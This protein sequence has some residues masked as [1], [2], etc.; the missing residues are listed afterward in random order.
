VLY[1]SPVPGGTYKTEKLKNKN[2]T[3]KPYPYITTRCSSRIHWLLSS[4]PPPVKQLLH[5]SYVYFPLLSQFGRSAHRRT[6]LDALNLG[7]WFLHLLIP[8][9]PTYFFFE[10]V[11]F[12]SFFTMTAPSPRNS[13]GIWWFLL[14]FRHASQPFRIR[15][16]NFQGGCHNGGKVFISS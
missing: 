15:P 2:K 7:R 8:F 6:V 5:I 12:P 4:K 9:S 13:A 16:H 10:A 1:P 14:S 11:L 3:K